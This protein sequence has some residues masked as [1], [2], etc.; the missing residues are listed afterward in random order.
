MYESLHMLFENGFCKKLSL[1]MISSLED[2][3]EKHQ[4]MHTETHTQR[5][6]SFNVQ[7]TPSHNWEF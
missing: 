4:H 1:C 5:Q 6:W 2:A 7:G 3:D